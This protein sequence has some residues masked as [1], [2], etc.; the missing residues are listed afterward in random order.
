MI[1]HF[2]FC[3]DFAENIQ[4][5]CHILIVGQKGAAKCPVSKFMNL[6]VLPINQSFAWFKLK[7]E[8][9][10]KRHNI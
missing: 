8:L 5:D 2:Y 4:I 10:C 3:T 7:F 9:K 1:Q 6:I